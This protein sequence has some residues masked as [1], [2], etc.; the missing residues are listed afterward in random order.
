M[1][2][3]LGAAALVSC[4][5]ESTGEGSM[6]ERPAAESPSSAEPIIPIGADPSSSTDPADPL[7]TD[8][9]TAAPAVPVVLD[10]LGLVAKTLSAYGDNECWLV[11][12]VLDCYSSIG[13][14]VYADEITDALTSIS[15]GD[16]HLCGVDA[17]GAVHCYGRGIEPHEEGADCAF[18]NC[19][20]SIVPAGTYKDVAAAGEYTCGL[21]T[22]G[23][24]DCWGEP[25]TII[26]GTFTD[27]DV[28]GSRLCGLTT[29]SRIVC[30]DSASSTLTG[31]YTQ[32]AVGPSVCGVTSGGVNCSDLPNQEGEFARISVGKNFACGLLVN[33]TPVCWGAGLR[34]PP[35]AGAFTAIASGDGYACASVEGKP[36]ICWGEDRGDGGAVLQCDFNQ[37]KLSGTLAGAPVEGDWSLSGSMIEYGSGVFNWELSLRDQESNTGL[38]L[39]SGADAVQDSEI[40]RL[41]L[42]DGQTVAVTSGVFM[43][44][45]EQAPSVYCVGGGTVSRAGDEALAELTA[46]SLLGS[47]PGVPVEGELQVC[48]GFG[49]SCGD[50]AGDS[51]NGTL[52]GQPMDT[53]LSGYLGIG[54]SFQAPM[55]AGFLL[56]TEE[57]DFTSTVTTGAL[58]SGLIFT[59]PAGP[60]GGAIYCAGDTSTWE[61][62]AGE[63]FSDNTLITMTGLSKLGGCV[64]AA[65]GT[66]QLSGCMR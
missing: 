26:T 15:L 22:D 17:A 56:W 7:G 18:N 35:P 34:V 1:S 44:P 52:D 24:V 16:E 39:L 50:V 57:R 54:G 45:S 42:N 4:G 9:S 6:L 29:D 46:M 31:S 38:L 21:L 10:P 14:S 36:P 60:H 47:C 66:D 13:S 25:P 48:F 61:E 19:G 41:A 33:G 62:I 23:T 30:N 49:E 32:M 8:S 65:P 2:G 53:A 59:D 28:Y 63:S 58:R 27:I 3:V 11:N 64:G 55:P 40:P 12:G 51:V 37:A 43:P 20:Q 5:E